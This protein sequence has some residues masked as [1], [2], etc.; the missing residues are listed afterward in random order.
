MF[1]TVVFLWAKKEDK[2]TEQW[3][4]RGSHCNYVVLQR[5]SER[6]RERERENR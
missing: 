5:E 2:R 1:R 6:E 3:L 4:S